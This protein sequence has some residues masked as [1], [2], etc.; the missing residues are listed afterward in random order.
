MLSV[1]LV[2]DMQKQHPK[3]E[4]RIGREIAII[5]IVKVIILLF[6]KH[7]WFDKPTIP[8]NFDHQAA[9]RIVGDTA[10]VAKNQ[11]KSP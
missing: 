7:I 3:S 8:K 6:I 2:L 9:Q 5:L 11:E 1:L 10:N 4:R